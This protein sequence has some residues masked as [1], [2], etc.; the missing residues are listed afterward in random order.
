MTWPPSVSEQRT[1]SA[2]IARNI[3]SIATMAEENN[4]ASR[5]SYD[6]AAQLDALANDLK[7]AI[8]RFTA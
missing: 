3:E 6:A 5:S 1:A 8:S 7:G 4:A 2:D